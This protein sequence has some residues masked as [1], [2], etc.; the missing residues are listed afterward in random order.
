MATLRHQMANV[1]SAAC[2]LVKLSVLKIVYPKNLSFTYMERFSPGVVIDTDR[3]SRI[4][5]G[6]RVSI[7]SRGRFAATG[8]GQLE[9]SDNTSFNV[10]CIVV[11]RNRIRI[12]KNVAIGPNVIMYDHN[13]IMG[14]VR[15]VKDTAF[16]LDEINIG[17]NTWIGAGVIVLAGARIG[18]NCIIAAGSV[19]TG[20]VPDNT[21]LVQKRAS[22]YMDVT[23]K[24]E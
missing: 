11:C 21:V 12:G 5:F 15:G 20:V 19:V 13:H 9:I 14:G 16:E 1:I 3:K 6:H 2:T 23:I 10:G 8:G 7:H 4:K 17:D 18:K 22:T 24:D